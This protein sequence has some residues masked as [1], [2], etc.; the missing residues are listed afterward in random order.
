MNNW[1]HYEPCAEGDACVI[2][3]RDMRHCPYE[4][5]S[6]TTGRQRVFHSYYIK[7]TLPGEEVSGHDLHSMHA[8]LL[9]LD[10]QLRARKLILVAAGVEP[11]FSESGLSFNSGFGYLPYCNQA[12][13][14]MDMPP[15]PER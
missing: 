7:V 5:G 14:I 12:V 4:I 15:L 13:H 10:H 11:S 6:V 2:D 3:E 9:D 8:A 1:L